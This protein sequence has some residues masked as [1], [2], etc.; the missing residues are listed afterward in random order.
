MIA[1]YTRPILFQ[2]AMVR[3][4]LD[5]SKTQ[6]RRI[7]KP[8]PDGKTWLENDA[9]GSVSWHNEGPPC[10]GTGVWEVPEYSGKVKCPYGQ[11]GDQLWVREAWG[12]RFSHSDFGAVALHWNDL[13]GPLKKYRTLQNLALYAMKADGQNCGGWI[14]SIHMPR[15]ASRITLEI[16]GVRV[17]R[18]QEISEAD[19]M[20]EGITVE[21]GVVVGTNCNGGVHQEETATR[22]YF[23]G[24]NEDGYE[25]A[26][27]AYRA[28]WESINGGDS[29]DE[30][31]WVWVVEFKVVTP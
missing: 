9:D 25:C 22:Y 28:L 2:G 13:R 21:R 5:G 30:N 24:G 7:V 20:A 4:L 31:P 23:E 29:W 17:E 10:C 11:P 1:A 12:A 16:T 27:D 14:P 18:L 6:T 8:Q 3:A 19:A 15:W 26:A